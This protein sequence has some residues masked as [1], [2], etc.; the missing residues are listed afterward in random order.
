MKIPI[1]IT[2]GPHAGQSGHI[3]SLMASRPGTVTVQ[4]QTGRAYLMP[5]N[6]VKKQPQEQK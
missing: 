3:I 1:I 6:I 4:L 2:A 5:A